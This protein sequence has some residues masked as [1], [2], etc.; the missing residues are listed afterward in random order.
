MITRIE[1]E[2]FLPF[3]KRISLDLRNR[4]VV[5]IRGDVRISASTD[6]NGAGKTSVPG[7]IS[8][9][10]FG[11]DMRGRKA[12][13]VA[14][15]FMD[16]P[17]M[18]KVY[19][20]D[21]IGEWTV[22]RQARPSKLIVTGI[23]G[24]GENEDIREI[25]KKIEQRLG[26]GLRTFK[27]A[28]V[29]GQGSFER[30]AQADQAEQM[31]MLDEIQGIDFKPSLERAKD[32]RK[33]LV[34]RAA[35]MGAE[36]GTFD[37]RAD[38]LR[39]Q[40]DHLVLARDNFENQKTVTLGAHK[41][42]CN[43]AAENVKRAN[44]EIE[45]AESQRQML[46]IMRAEIKKVQDLDNERVRVERI[47][48]TAANEARNAAGRLT[49]IEE[50]LSDLFEN[51]VCP[52]C[53]QPVAARK[54]AIRKIFQPEID[55]IAATLSLA[56]A[57]AEGAKRAYDV[58]AADVTKQNQKLLTLTPPLQ[59]TAA[60]Y[61][62]A[63]EN[64]LSAA[65]GKV[66]AGALEG[67]EA[68]QSRAQAAYK[69]AKTATWGGA[70]A[71]SKA[72]ND[73]AD[74]QDARSA[75]DGRLEKIE[76][77][78]TMADYCVET[79]GDRGLRSMM[80][81]GVADYVNNQIRQHLEILACGEATMRM[82]ATTDLKKGGVKE[83]ISFKPTWAWGGEGA[84]SGSGGQDRRM[85]L[86]VFAATQ[87]LAERARAFP[88]KVY[89]EVFDAL[90]GRGKELA[91]EWLRKQAK[92]RGTVLLITHSKEMEALVEPDT[93]WTVVMDQDGAHVEES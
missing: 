23:P 67:F 1:A 54:A 63:L 6:S 24:I 16:G 79:L 8:F 22:E 41:A 26:F 73:L 20:E 35:T 4:G 29:F 39:E 76:A 82:S 47:W 10:L 69:A 62:G 65:Q 77:A 85:D 33:D 46:G 48:S 68:E 12:A 42:A 18:A 40:I 61:L 52:S 64:L 84:E 2:D 78:I 55:T 59:R 31:R 57:D 36:I 37:A 44:T 87:D 71:L 50:R 7:I 56:A 21:E 83:R 89:D 53:R 66:R 19:L 58:A 80:V 72:G 49:E 43:A 91:A 27:N 11:E 74:V 32:W 14:N 28:V 75:Q 34:A 60:N 17:A 90:D 3:R 45:V 81:D 70:D 13:A 38:A 5:L 15:R 9:A 25:Q 86:A 92:N 93:T 88:I 51:D 30:F